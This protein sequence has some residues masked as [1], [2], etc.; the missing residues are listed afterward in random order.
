MDGLHTKDCALEGSKLFGSTER[1]LD[2]PPGVKYDLDQLKK[3]IYLPCSNTR[4]RKTCIEEFFNFVDHGV[5]HT[6]LVM[7]ADGSNS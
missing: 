3:V 4:A 6:T 1:K 2:L 7:E 5:A